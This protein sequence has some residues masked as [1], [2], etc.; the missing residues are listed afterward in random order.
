MERI[1]AMTLKPRTFLATLLLLSGLLTAVPVAQA[2][3]VPIGDQDLEQGDLQP[4]DCANLDE[5]LAGA[6]GCDTSDTV[7]DFV[8]FTGELEGPDA[9]GYDEALTENTNARDFI[10][11]VVNFA[12]SFVGLI[13]VVTVIYGGLLYVTSR[14][15]EEQTSKAKKAITYSVIGIVIIMGSFAFVN[16]IL[17]VGGGGSTG[18]GNGT[19]LNGETI[20]ESGAAFDVKDV[21]DEIEQI[22]EE[23][24]EAYQTLLAVNK[25]VSSMQALEMPVVVEVTERERSLGGVIDFTTEYFTGEDDDFADTYTVLEEARVDAYTTSLARAAQNIMSET[26]ALSDT[27]EDA[28]QLYQYLQYG[29]RNF[30]ADGDPEAE[31]CNTLSFNVRDR[32]VNGNL[33]WTR[34]DAEVQVVDPYICNYIAAILQSAESD[35]L[36]VIGDSGVGLIGRFEELKALFDVS[37]NASGSNLTGIVMALSNA[38]TALTNAKT[39]ISNSTIQE[40][41]YAMN[42]LYELVKNVEFV[43][44]RLTATVVEGN[45]PL[46]VRFDILGTEDPSGNTVEDAQIQWDLDGNGV[47][48]EA[49]VGEDLGADSISYIFDQAGTYRVKVRVLSS[50]PDIAAGVSTVSIRVQPAK[51]LIVINATVGSNGPQ[52]IANFIQSPAINKPKFKVTASEASSEAGILFDA[53]ESTDGE[54]NVSGIRYYEWDFGDNETEAG[55]F[56]QAATIRHFYAQEG[57]YDVSLTVT[58]QDGVKDSKYF[59][60][61]V[62]T[63]AARINASPALGI[64]GTTFTLDGSSSTAD[65]G[66][67]R[68]YQWSVSK[69]G[70]AAINLSQNT[71][72]SIQVTLNEPGIYDVNLNVSDTSSKSDAATAFVVVE[73]Q[74]PVVTYTYEIENENQPSIVTFDAR[75]SYDPDPNDRLEFSW[76]FGGFEGEDY[77]ILEE[78]EDQSEVT[79]QFLDTGAY[80]VLLTGHDQHPQA[81]QKSDT[82]TATI[83]VNSI[84]DV[85]LTVSGDEA[86]HLNQDGEAEVEF[87][88]ESE[89]GSAFQIEY[90]DGEVDFTDTLTNGRAIFTHTYKQAGVFYVKLTTYDDSEQEE[91]NTDTVR[92]Y[93]GSGNA[94]IAVIGIGAEN[95]DIGTGPSFVGS[96]KT[97]FTFSAS[98]SVNVDGSNQNL[99]YSWNFGDG[100]TAN[101]ATVTHK[102]T[103][104]ATYNVTLTV[105]DKNDPSIS[106]EAV[107]PIQIQGIEPKIQSISVV[108]VSTTELTTPLKVNVSVTASDDD[109]KITYIRGWYYDL[110]DS[111]TPLGTVISESGNFTLTLNTNGEEGEN[112]EYGFAVEVTDNDNQTVS[113]FDQLDPADIPTL[114]VINGPNDSPVASFSVDKSSRY[115]GEEVTFSSLSY[116]P[117]GEIV[118]YWWDIEG[119]GFY[120]NEPTQVSSYTYEFSQVHSE[121]IPVRLK[122]EDSAGATAESEPVMIYVDSLAEDPDAKFLTDID[123]TYVQFRNNS[124]VDSENG[125]E[126]A[127]T[128]WDFDLQNDSDGNGVKDD[129]FDSFEE[130]PTYNYEEFGVYKVKMTVVDTVGQSDTV[131]QDIEVKETAAPVAAFTFTVD[132]KNVTFRNTSTVDTE[133]GVDVRTYA[134]DFDTT[135]DSNGDSETDNDTDAELKNP[136]HEYADYGTYE[137]TLTV[138]DT[139]G[140]IDTVTQTVE[141]ENPIQAL[142][143]ILSSVPQANSLS[144]ILLRQDGQEV[145]FYFGAEGG[146]EDY[147]FSLDKNIFYDSNADGIR[148]NDEDYSSSSPGSWKTPFFISYGQIVTKLTVTDNETGDR[149]ISTLQVVFEGHLGSANLFNATPKQM[150]LLILSAALTAALGVSMAFRYKPLPRR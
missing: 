31:A 61:Y 9:A 113:S 13:C 24:V 44:V 77:I 78:S 140:K 8:D 43:Q 92:V 79:V 49:A 119:D 64:A 5:S 100:S 130:N 112:K 27:Y 135:L 147:H 33:G 30:V 102:F 75:N 126:L 40:I 103:E 138:V 76:D 28:Y 117:D 74:A 97:T 41:Q 60:L 11:S 116:D 98:N 20:N 120:N 105:K 110:D 89:F 122:V 139:Y 101:Q 141:I 38:Q 128:Y 85:D 146:S 42:E 91:T 114:S 25:E 46:L 26:D 1:L 99:T 47:Y 107:V 18:D 106:D 94:P 71:G 48:D 23:Y 55:N 68:N 143:A 86:R 148:D 62:A 52:A 66:S 67:I 115:V 90:G 51:S 108:P 6:F 133:H 121:G 36:E 144:Q 35:Y 129:D 53:S 4:E 131:T 12:L 142:N 37:E 88:A 124:F 16:T 50:E 123:G 149:D 22:T 69:Q 14:G 15:D 125:A 58:D 145:S 65:V 87:T 19:A 29:S 83:Q 72:S 73:S 84:L 63:P 80:T 56:E 118:T 82:A 45:A 96:V 34:T 2:I 7:T 104:K 137:V 81:I 111:A 109:G 54:G 93:I 70:G 3:S 95:T 17:Q 136:S 21:L 127:G 150:A 132:E 39:V 10:Q 32:E 59:K 134:W 57:V